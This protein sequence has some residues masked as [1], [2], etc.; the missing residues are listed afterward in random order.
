MQLMLLTAQHINKS[1]YTY[2][3]VYK[4][5]F[6]CYTGNSI[7]CILNM[8]PGCKEEQNVKFTNK[9]VEGTTI[10]D[11]DILTCSAIHMYFDRLVV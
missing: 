1:L 5:E 4:Q 7:N 2:V 6:M 8:V 3:T 11:C 10:S 9:I